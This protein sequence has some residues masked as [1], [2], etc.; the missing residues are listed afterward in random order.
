MFVLGIDTA[1][2][3]P[4]VALVDARTGSATGIVGEGRAQSVLALAEQLLQQVGATPSDL[5]GVVVGTGPGG[6]TGLRV[7]VT[8]ARGI[9]S[10]LG[11]PTVVSSARPSR[12]RSGMHGTC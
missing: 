11:V 5:T 6:F 8:T 3:R 1:A 10:A 9:G 2:E 12:P 7:G 4:V